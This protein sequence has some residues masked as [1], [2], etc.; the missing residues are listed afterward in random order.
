MPDDEFMQ[1]PEG[2]EPNEEGSLA[3]MADAPEWAVIPPGGN[4]FANATWLEAGGQYRSL[5]ESVLAYEELEQLRGLSYGVYWRRK[6]KPQRKGR[7]GDEPIYASVEI[8]APR[9][10]WVAYAEGCETFPRLLI[11]L[12]WQH[13]EDARDEGMY[14]HA[15]AVRRELHHALSAL[16]VTND[17]VS[18]VAPDV[19]AFAHTVGRFGL[20]NPGLVSLQQQFELFNGGIDG[21][22]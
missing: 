3:Y 21:S 2:D 6:S 7:W 9:M 12:H 11:D 16:E 13:F 4:V 20:S 1:E 5:V 22:N 15:D 14:V 17:I 19:A 10:V 8:V 18:K